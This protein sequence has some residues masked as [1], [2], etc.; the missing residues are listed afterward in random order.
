MQASRQYRQTTL[1]ISGLGLGM[2]SRKSRLYLVVN[3]E[4]LSEGIAPR[5]RGLIVR[6]LLRVVQIIE[7]DAIYLF[8]SHCEL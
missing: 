8:Q 4:I 1:R 7:V 2:T 5:W 6:N 3:I